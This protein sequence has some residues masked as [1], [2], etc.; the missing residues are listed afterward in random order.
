MS[1]VS[2]QVPASTS[3][4]G[5]GFDCVGIALGLWLKLD[6]ALLDDGASA[7]ELR[8]RGTLESVEVA[9]DE[10]R[11]VR[12]FR[13]ACVAAGVAR[14]RSVVLDATSD[15]PVGRGLGSSAAATVAGALAANALLGLGLDNPALLELCA[16]IEGHPDNAAP[17]LEL[18]ATLVAPGNGHRVVTRLDVHPDLSF[19]FAVP[20]FAVHTDSA[21]AILPRAVSHQTA[22]VA[23]AHAAA[24]V[25]GLARGDGALLAIALDDVLH[26]PFRSRLVPGYADVTAAARAAG[27]F[28]ATL[29]GS[30]SSILAITTSSKAIVVG[31]A[32]AQ[33]WRGRGIT[34]AIIHPPLV[35]EALCL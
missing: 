19:V 16:A 1:P 20:S 28:G 5:A 3:N 23:A 8:R 13:A 15:I 32:M 18:G 17:A 4:V 6:A 2:L 26:V 25:Q 9:P 7:I 33:A 11:I 12:G 29:S 10:D 27:A 30:G 34:A 21:R 24:L 22:T 31:S 14:P 35:T